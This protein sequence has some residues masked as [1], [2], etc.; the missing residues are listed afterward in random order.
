M[1]ACLARL[2]GINIPLWHGET[3]ICERFVLDMLVD[4]SVAFGEEDLHRRLP[5]RLYLWLLPTNPKIF[6]LDLDV[7]TIQDRRPDLC[8]D[9]FL[10][11]RLEVYRRIS[12]DLSLQRL[13]S[14]LPV[15][16]L[17]TIIRKSV[18]GVDAT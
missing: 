1:D 9:R 17:N 15:K 18:G 7:A 2:V 14:S 10:N 12:S 8:S 5:G 4:L 6:I 11:T 13:S 3:V 16:I